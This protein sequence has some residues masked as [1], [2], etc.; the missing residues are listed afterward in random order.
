MHE[1]GGS[2]EDLPNDLFIEMHKSLMK[3]CNKHHKKFY[4]IIEKNIVF[5]GI[6]LRVFYYNFGLMWKRSKSIEKKKV[7]L[8]EGI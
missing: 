8:G 5:I 7:K 2:S 1:W 3:F 6:L 4:F